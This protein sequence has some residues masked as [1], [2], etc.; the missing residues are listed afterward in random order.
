M[1]VKAFLHNQIVHLSKSHNL[2]L[3]TNIKDPSELMLSGNN[4]VIK[5][6][7]I[8]RKISLW[9]D[10]KAFLI[11]LK[12]FKKNKFDLVYS[13]TPK[14]GILAMFASFLVRIHCRI[15]TFTGQV[16]ITRTGI[17]RLLLKGGDKLLSKFATHLLAD[18]VSQMNFLVNEKVVKENKIKV[19]ANGSISGVDLNRFKTNIISRN[20]IRSELEID[21]SD[22]V[23]IF[24]GRLD[25]DKGVIDLVDAFKLL[26]SH[27]T[28]VKLILVGPDEANIKDQILKKTQS[29]SK[30]IRF[31]DFSEYPENYMNAA[32]ILCLPSYREGFGSVV[33]EAAAI[34]IPAIGSD[35]YGINDAIDNNVTGLLFPVG[36]T[37]A[38]YEAM[39]LLISNKNLRQRFGQAAKCRAVT[40][41][42]QEHVTRAYVNYFEDAI[43]S[44]NSK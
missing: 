16:W 26:A 38:L 20:E 18:S 7:E 37:Q 43:N 34:G 44:F 31:I 22:L 9:S 29:I 35:I 2:T 1:T 40:L 33:I 15:H 24:I 12:L 30:Y 8:V 41:Y 13:V 6:I 36:N 23:I 10:L 27:N 39:Q 28:Y 25:P 14:A 11:L 32:D 5:P 4:L 42:S 19:L 3:V 21:T 17:A